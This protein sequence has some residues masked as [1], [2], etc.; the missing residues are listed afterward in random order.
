MHYGLSIVVMQL[1]THLDVQTRGIFLR[2][3]WR[4]IMTGRERSVAVEPLVNGLLGDRKDKR[5]E[6]RLIFFR[7]RI[8]KQDSKRG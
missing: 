4:S 2:G 7:I 8:E 1:S 3:D 6:Q 5:P